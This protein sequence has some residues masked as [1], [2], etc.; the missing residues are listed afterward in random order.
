MRTTSGTTGK[1]N[2]P[3]QPGPATDVVVTASLFGIPGETDASCGGNVCIGQGIEWSISDPNAV[4]KMKVVFIESPALAHGE[5][6]KTANIY[7]DDVLLPN[8]EGKI[9][10]MCVSDR[11]RTEGGGSKFT[12]KVD[13]QDPHGRH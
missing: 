11:D 6:V 4:G 10:I 5:D 8:C 2:I 1:I 13:G 9:K 3:P 7:K 12:I